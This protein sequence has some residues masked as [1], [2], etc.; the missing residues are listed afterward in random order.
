VVIQ[1]ATAVNAELRKGSAAQNGDV[2]VGRLIDRLVTAALR[3][4]RLVSVPRCC[5]R[6]R[7]HGLLRGSTP[8][9][10]PTSARIK[11]S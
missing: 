1:G 6:R 11:C 7:A 8:M 10:F 4:R 5:L 9:P 2:N 3:H